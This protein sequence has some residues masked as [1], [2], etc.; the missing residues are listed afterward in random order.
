MG[1]REKVLKAMGK[2][3]KRYALLICVSSKGVL[4]KQTSVHRSCSFH[5]YE[6]R[7]GNGLLQLHMTDIFAQIYH[8]PPTAF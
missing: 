5:M 2:F 1:E 8:L 3:E 7:L 4:G 6:R